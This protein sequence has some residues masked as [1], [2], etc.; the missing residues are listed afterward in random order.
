ML[1]DWGGRCIKRLQRP[2]LFRECLILNTAFELQFEG[3]IGFQQNK[4]WRKKC[5]VEWQRQCQWEKIEMCMFLVILPK[6]VFCHLLTSKICKW[7]KHSTYSQS[8]PRD[9]GRAASAT[10]QPTA[11]GLCFLPFVCFEQPEERSRSSGFVREWHVRRA[12]E[13]P[14]QQKEQHMQTHRRSSCSFCFQL[15]VRRRITTSNSLHLS[16]TGVKTSLSL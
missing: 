13:R 3:L 1:T 9:T 16:G 6:L 2:G 8:C 14:S 11:V 7:N 4:S 12:G 15:T 5:Q 10:P